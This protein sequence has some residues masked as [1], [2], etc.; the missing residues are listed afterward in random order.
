MLAPS[1]DAKSNRALQ[2]IIMKFTWWRIMKDSLFA[3]DQIITMTKVFR[4]ILHITT[5]N[6]FV[7]Q[8]STEQEFFALLL[9]SK[10]GL[11]LSDQA[12][13]PVE[14]KA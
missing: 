13:G 4:E 2:L 14:S 5:W 1:S 3:S 10:R 12:L 6:C 8:A 9:N 7:W 11:S